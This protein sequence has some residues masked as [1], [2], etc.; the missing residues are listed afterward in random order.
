MR[1]F[2]VSVLS[3]LFYQFCFH[4]KGVEDSAAYFCT[5]IAETKTSTVGKFW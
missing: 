4:I 2:A 5:E 1:C 3:V